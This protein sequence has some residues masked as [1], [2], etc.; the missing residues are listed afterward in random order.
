MD[1]LRAVEWVR[2]H[3]AVIKGNISRYRNFSPYEECD[4]MQEAFEAAMIATL[5]SR[6]KGIPFEAAFWKIFR[7]QVCLFTPNPDDLSNGSNSVPSHL[8][9]VDIDSV[10]ITQRPKKKSKRPCIEA[11]YDAV[12]HFLTEKEQQAISLSLGITEEG[13]LSNYEIAERL[14]C[15]AANVRDILGRANRRLKCLVMKGSI[16]PSRLR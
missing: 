11:V 8:C 5:R 10:T 9:S 7:R 16:D 14:G 15:S 2:D 13:R 6:N 12:S 4:Y 3:E 1:F